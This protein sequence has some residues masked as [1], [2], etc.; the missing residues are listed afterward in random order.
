MPVQSI[1]PPAATTADAHA[2]RI[3]RW[4]QRYFFFGF[5]RTFWNAR[6]FA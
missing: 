2:Q 1:I 3:G 4:P 5:V 6:T